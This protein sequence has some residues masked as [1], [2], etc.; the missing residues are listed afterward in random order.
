MDNEELVLLYQKGNKKVLNK[1]IAQNTGIL[2]KLSNKYMGINKALEF[3]DLFNSGVVGFIYAVNRY[4]FNGHEKAKFITYAVHYINRYIYSCVNGWSNKDRENNKF[5]NSFI[6]LD[7]PV[8]NSSGSENIDIKDTIESN[9]DGFKNI[10]DKIYL[11][12]LRNDLEKYMI[13][14]N[15]LI[16]REVI[17][18]RYGW[19]CKPCSHAE[20]AEILNISKL[21]TRQFENEALRKLRRGNVGRELKNKYKDEV[22]AYHGYSY[23]A[24]ERM[25]DEEIEGLCHR[26]VI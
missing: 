8:G 24:V 14:A 23:R 22:V 13:E 21:R 17:Q 2:I 12:Q 7:A 20:I 16:E 19:N 9:E 11:N 15:T 4:D 3:D 26:L 10:E 1:L 5:Y 25:I 6:S 18:L